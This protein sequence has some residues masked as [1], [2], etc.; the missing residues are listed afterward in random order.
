MNTL[1]MMVTLFVVAFLTVSVYGCAPNKMEIDLLNKKVTELETK[2]DTLQKGMG[3]QQF[4][5][6]I[7]SSQLFKSPLEQ[8]FSSPEFWENTYD[9]SEADCSRRCIKDLQTHR[10]QCMNIPDDNA[11]LQCFQEASDRAANCHR[12]CAN[13]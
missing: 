3:D 7:T 5:S 11:R 8:F 6:M 12:Q 9:S 13:L 1:R 4:K 10:A 2:V